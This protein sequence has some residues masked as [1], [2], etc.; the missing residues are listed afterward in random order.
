[1]TYKNKFPFRI[2]STSYVLPDKI[3]PN[4]LF[5][6][7]IVDD[8]ELLF[9]E[10]VNNSSFLSNAE[11]D[12]LEIISKNSGI[13]YSV[14]CPLDISAGLSDKISQERFVFQIEQIMRETK[15]LRV[16]GFIVH[17]DGLPAVYT[18]DEEIMWTENVNKVCRK[19]C[20][21]DK[22]DTSKICIENLSYDPRLNF[23]IISKY[24]FSACMDIG[25]LWINRHDVDTY[26]KHLLPL[27][28]IIHLHGVA[29]VKDHRSLKVNDQQQLMNF[30]ANYL[31]SYT[32]VV[33]I[34]TFKKDPTFESLEILKKLWD[35]LHL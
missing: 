35:Q 33:T 14:H 12:E 32:N 34:E 8:V 30:I 9:F 19:I 15:A 6:S 20:A 4:V 22:V 25:H 28:K 2:G 24:G 5:M 27:T 16:S 31:K 11:A 21:I 23:D 17:L 1:M 10:S 18:A 13:S 7:S 29:D 3:V 26:C